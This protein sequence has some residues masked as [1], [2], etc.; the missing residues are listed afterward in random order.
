MQFD[1]SPGTRALCR[2]GIA[3]QEEEEAAALDAAVMT[4]VAAT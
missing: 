1:E 2:A 4:Y 3:A